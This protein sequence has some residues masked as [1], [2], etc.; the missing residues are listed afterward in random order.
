MVQVCVPD[1]PTLAQKLRGHPRVSDVKD[2]SQPYLEFVQGPWK[3]RVYVADSSCEISGLTELIDNN[4]LVCAD[5]TS[6]PSA[7]VT[8]ALLALGPI[9]R[10]GLI[11]EP[12]VLQSNSAVDADELHRELST[13]GWS[14]EVVVSV[15]PMDLNGV[16]AATALVEVASANAPED[17]DLIYEEAFGRSF[18]V[19]Q[20]DVSDWDISL[21]KDQ[22]FAVFRLRLTPGDDTSL[23]R[24]Q[25]LADANGKCGAAQIIHRMNVM[26]G[27]EESLGL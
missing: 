3:R 25:I 12:P 14:E 8:L 5:A 6:V 19:R 11:V 16:L 7:G 24:I 27:F 22:P 17:L 20:D 10:S 26:C 13:L 2:F 18:F 21:V 23:L 4:P 9:A 1:I 15:E